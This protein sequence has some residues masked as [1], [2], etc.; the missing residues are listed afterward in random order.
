[1]FFSLTV[2]IYCAHLTPSEGCLGLAEG[3]G[4]EWKGKRAKPVDILLKNVK[5][6]E[7]PEINATYFPSLFQF[8]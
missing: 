6:M 7:W 3:N 1:M 2:A 8:T 5:I 4:K